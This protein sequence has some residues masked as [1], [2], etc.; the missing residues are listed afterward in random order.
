MAN[1]HGVRPRVRRGD[2]SLKGLALPRA[3]EGK[4]ELVPTFYKSMRGRKS[5]IVS[6]KEVVAT[7]ELYTFTRQ[8]TATVVCSCCRD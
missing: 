5:E 1:V 2:L 6:L 8:I 3:F 7:A 4:R